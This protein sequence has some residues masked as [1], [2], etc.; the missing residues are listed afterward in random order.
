MRLGTRPES[1]SEPCL[2]ELLFLQEHADG[3]V[4]HQRHP[5]DFRPFTPSDLEGRLVEA[6][7]AVVGSSYREDAQRYAIAATRDP[8]S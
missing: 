3:S 1:L 2:A 8:G 7:F 4:T 6:G 5:I